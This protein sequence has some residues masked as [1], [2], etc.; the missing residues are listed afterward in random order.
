MRPQTLPLCPS[1]GFSRKG[2]CG[3]GAPESKTGL[4]S[5]KQYLLDGRNA[6]PLCSSWLGLSS[7]RPMR[8]QGG[9]KH[10]DASCGCPIP[11]GIQILLRKM[12][13]PIH[14]GGLI[15]GSNY[16]SEFHSTTP[17]PKM[18]KPGAS[19]IFPVSP[20]G[21]R[22]RTCSAIAAIYPSIRLHS[23]CLSHSPETPASQIPIGVTIQT[24]RCRRNPSK[25]EESKKKTRITVRLTKT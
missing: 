19:T 8:A 10:V 18:S 6:A 7:A 15:P 24:H 21:N 13:A 16:Q 25:P 5:R 23:R 12:V 22:V 11:E 2:L 17:A 3:Q 4:S 14:P 20:I 9:K 1:F